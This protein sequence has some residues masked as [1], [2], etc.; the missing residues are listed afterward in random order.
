MLKAFADM[1][2]KNLPERTFDFLD[3]NFVEEIHDSNT[4]RQIIWSALTESRADVMSDYYELDDGLLVSIYFK[5]PPGRLLRRQWTAEPRVFPEFSEWSDHLSDTLSVSTSAESSRYYEIPVQKVG[6]L[7][8]Q[9]KFSF[10]SDNS[11]IRVDKYYAGQKRMA[12]SHIIKDNFM[13][14]VCERPRH[15]KEK[16]SEEDGLRGIDARKLMDNTCDFWLKF[17]NGVRLLIEMQDGLRADVENIP[18]S[19]LPAWLEK[20]LESEQKKLLATKSDEDLI[21]KLGTIDVSEQVIST[22][23]H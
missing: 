12:V 4:L 21:E 19:K 3:R 7:K 10:P 1:M 18:P 22:L 11:I 6:L 8:N 20:K 13:F 23:E 17:D 9:T 5:N 14:G 2:G 15:Y 16:V